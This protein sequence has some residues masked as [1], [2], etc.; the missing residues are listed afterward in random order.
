MNVEMKWWI[1][2]GWHY[3]VQIYKGGWDKGVAIM[4]WKSKGG[5]NR[6]QYDVRITR[7]VG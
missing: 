6:G 5:C 1:A 2:K 3:D 7:A 4:M